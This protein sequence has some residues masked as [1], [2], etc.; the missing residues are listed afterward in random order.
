[1]TCSEEWRPV[2]G[3][4]RYEVSSLGR[5]RAVRYL[6]GKGHTRKTRN[7]APQRSPKGHWTVALVRGSGNKQVKLALGRVVLEA[8]GFESRPDEIVLHGPLGRDVNTLDNLSFGTHAQN[9]GPDRARDGTR[10]AG[11]EHPRTHLSESDIRHIRGLRGTIP[12]SEIG[13]R[14][15]IDQTTVSNIQLRKSFREVL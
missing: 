4:P 11:C 10:L 15:G 2:K 1:M 8:F 12:Q 6:D 5:V 3:F 7:I 9:N 13:Q 14:Y